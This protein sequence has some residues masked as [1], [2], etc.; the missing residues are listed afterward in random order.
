MTRYW[1][2]ALL[3]LVVGLLT[4]MVC[5]LLVS[6]LT[7][8]KAPTLQW[9]HL[10]DPTRDGYDSYLPCVRTSGWLLPTVTCYPTESRS[11]TLTLHGPDPECREPADDP[12]A[13]RTTR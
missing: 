10:K 7:P 8:P 13:C 4:F 11:M 9:V 12:T 6:A 1:G 5:G 2:A 3:G